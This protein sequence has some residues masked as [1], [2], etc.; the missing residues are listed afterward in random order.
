M[1]AHTCYN[2]LSTIPYQ[3]EGKDTVNKELNLTHVR[4]VDIEEEISKEFSK[5]I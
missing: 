4:I 5:V 1:N 3:S 2:V